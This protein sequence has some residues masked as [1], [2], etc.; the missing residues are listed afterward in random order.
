MIQLDTILTY[1]IEM[2]FISDNEIVL[3]FDSG[4]SVYQNGV[5]KVSGIKSIDFMDGTNTTVQ[6]DQSNGR[7]R[8][9]VNSSGGGG[10]G[11]GGAGSDT[12]AIHDN[13]RGGGR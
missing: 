2:D 11:G 9:Y 7:A 4:L 6:I 8:V 1:D 3:N 5:K 10:G 12:T 13:E